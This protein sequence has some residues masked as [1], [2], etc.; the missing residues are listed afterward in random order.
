MG[1][2]DV[3]QTEILT[4]ELLVHDPST[5]EFEVAVE[6]LKVHKSPGTEQIPAELI[7]AGGRTKHCEIHKLIRSVWG[8]EELSGKS[9][10]VY[11]FIRRVKNRL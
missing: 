2:S 11:L 5:F 10:S 9:E 7:N 1:V 6:K 4:A 8:K 3:R